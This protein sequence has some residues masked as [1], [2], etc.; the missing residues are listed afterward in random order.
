[1]SVPPPD[2]QLFHPLVRC[3]FVRSS[4]FFFRTESPPP[5]TNAMKR[6]NESARAASEDDEEEEV[7]ELSVVKRPTKKKVKRSEF[8]GLA[9]EV[10]A[11]AS[12]VR[13]LARDVRGLT[14][15]FRAF[16]QQRQKQMPQ[17]GSAAP[18]D[19]L[20]PAVGANMGA[21]G[22]NGGVGPEFSVVKGGG[23]TGGGVRI[24]EHTA[25][26]AKIAAND[27]GDQG[28][29]TW[30]NGRSCPHMVI[31]GG[32]AWY[33]GRDTMKS[34]LHDVVKVTETVFKQ[35][36]GHLEY[37][38]LQFV[39]PDDEEV[40][41]PLET[42]LALFSRAIV[43]LARRAFVRPGDRG[44]AGF[45]IRALS[46]ALRTGI[47]L[48]GTHT[49]QFYAKMR[50]SSNRHLVA[51]IVTVD[52]AEYARAIHGRAGWLRS[53]FDQAP[54][55]SEFG[56]AVV[57]TWRH[58]IMHINAGDL[59]NAPDPP[60]RNASLAACRRW[61]RTGECRYGQSCTFVASHVA[62]NSKKRRKSNI[63]DA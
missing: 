47:D 61:E 48:L 40:S 9:G 57:P 17:G 62:M 7:G 28:M 6:H 34:V 31:F 37:E 51:E 21:G 15:D 27:V 22:R 52:L 33:T 14:R 13:G 49:T 26:Q 30:Y 12:V 41:L 56:L 42:H 4:F 58:L 39:L 18:A 20:D 16:A 25:L 63:G 5:L 43:A 23:G 3:P 53:K 19:P 24:S 54:P 32:E 35:L 45:R 38:F 44:S 2:T 11:L 8:D 50:L 29:R 46:E 1:M 36:D 59:I 10:R 60:A 55:V